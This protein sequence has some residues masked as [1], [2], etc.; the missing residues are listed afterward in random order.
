MKKHIVS[1]V[2]LGAAFAIPAQ[3]SEFMDEAWA[4]AACDAWNQDATL[5]TEL[6]QIT[7]EDNGY[8]WIANDKGRGYK[9]V[10]MY[11]TDCGA[12]SKVQLTI[13][14]KDGKAMCTYG[15]KPD[16]KAMDFGVDY[17]MHAQD[18]NWT[19]M[20][21]GRWGCGAMGAMM[22]GKLKFT[23]PKMEAMAVM[24]P[25]ESFLRLTGKVAGTK[26]PCVPPAAN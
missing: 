12:D 17:L 14:L 26:T 9:L 10:Q 23:G 3:A 15:G 4:K 1:A 25:F 19:C 2:L 16:G 20:G 18:A 5:T 21:E 6:V 24:A 11:R 22:S 8:Q 7:G 13:S